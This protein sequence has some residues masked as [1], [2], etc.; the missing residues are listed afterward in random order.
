MS[1]E[2]QR[3][4]SKE[5]LYCGLIVDNKPTLEEAIQVASEAYMDFVIAPLFK[6]STTQQ[7]QVT[8]LLESTISSTEKYLNSQEWSHIVVAK[9]DWC[10]QLDHS[11]T[12]VRQQ[13]ESRFI[14]ELNFASYMS[15][16]AVLL[17]TPNGKRFAN[18][19]RVVNDAL[20][21]SNYTTIWMQFPIEF[22]KNDSKVSIG[23][24]GYFDD[25]N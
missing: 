10:K 5:H 4:S 25:L 13:A 9:V 23:I 3:S 20:R 24:V 17:P 15:L 22:T 19:A 21:K 11:D 12:K 14:Q 6:P 7:Q 8:P 1:S 2:E 16:P 18:Y